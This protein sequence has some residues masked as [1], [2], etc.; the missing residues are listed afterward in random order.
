ME[1]VFFFSVL[2]PFW[3]LALSVSV[4]SG[5]GAGY[6]PTD[7]HGSQTPAIYR[8]NSFRGNTPFRFNVVGK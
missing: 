6:H 1:V 3:A 2:R 4:L 8:G 5:Y 7:E